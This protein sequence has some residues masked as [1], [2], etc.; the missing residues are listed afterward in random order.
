[1]IRIYDRYFLKNQTTVFNSHHQQGAS[2]SDIRI[3]KAANEIVRM[4][5]AEL[6]KGFE[7]ICYHWSRNSA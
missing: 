4:V 1:M 2:D 3:W 5:L 7:S 6:Y